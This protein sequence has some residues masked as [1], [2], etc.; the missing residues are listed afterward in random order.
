MEIILLILAWTGFVVPLLW[1]LAYVARRQWRR[2]L[3]AAALAAVLLAPLLLYDLRGYMTDPGSSAGCR[4]AVAG[5]RRAAIG[6]R[7]PGAD[8]ANKCASDSSRLAD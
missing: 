1:V 6:Q 2:A 3:A 5:S 8:H 7:E 4:V